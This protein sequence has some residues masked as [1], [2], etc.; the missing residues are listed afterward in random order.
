MDK[1]EMSFCALCFDSLTC[2][3]LHYHDYHW[4]PFC[5]YKQ[6]GL[7]CYNCYLNGL[8]QQA[9][10]LDHY[11]PNLNNTHHSS[12]YQSPLPSKNHKYQYLL[13]SHLRTSLPLAPGQPPLMTYLLSLTQDITL[14]TAP[15]TH[16]WTPSDRLPPY[17]FS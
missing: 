12:H 8:I 6:N 16:S 17:L 13:I 10:L 2:A 3:L 5:S 14:H 15:L 9:S 7:I 1:T 4:T 11:K